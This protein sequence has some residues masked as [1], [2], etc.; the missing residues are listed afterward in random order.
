MKYTK[1]N[2][3]IDCKESKNKQNKVIRENK[4]IINNKQP[5]FKN[6]HEHYKCNK[7]DKNFTIV[8]KSFLSNKTNKLFLLIVSI[9]LIFSVLSY[10]K[11]IFSEYL[12]G[13]IGFEVMVIITFIYSYYN[14]F[15]LY[16]N[17]LISL[18]NHEVIFDKR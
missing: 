5:I 12:F 10:L 15:N 4:I 14:N 1:I 3:I 2:L 17:L 11:S 6:T 13:L 8:K 7:C 18:K 9:G 16:N